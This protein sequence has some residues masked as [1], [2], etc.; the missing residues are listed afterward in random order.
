MVWVFGRP[1]ILAAL[2]PKVVVTTAG[3]E[4]TNYFFRHWILFKAVSSIESTDEVVVRLVDGR[5]LKV[6]AGSWSLVGRMRGNPAQRAMRE[7]ISAA[8]EKAK[9]DGGNVEV[10][11]PAVST[12]VVLESLAYLHLK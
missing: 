12:L 6:A 11:I 8:M 1:M 9:E 7:Q 3:L 4:V 5:R 10:S 2:N